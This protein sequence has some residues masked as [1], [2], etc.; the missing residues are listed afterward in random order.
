M[1]IVII[2]RLF[3]KSILDSGPVS[4]CTGLLQQ[5]WQSSEK[6]QHFKMKHNNYSTPCIRY[7]KGTVAMRHY[8]AG[9]MEHGP[10]RLQELN[11]K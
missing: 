5:I 11:V 8:A 7:L 3:Q 4:V 9:V 1:N 6:S 10:R 2:S